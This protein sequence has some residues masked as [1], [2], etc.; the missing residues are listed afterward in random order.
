MARA[1]ITATWDDVPHLS[2]TAKAELLASY[3]SHQR[4]ARSRGIPSLGSGAIYPYAPEDIAEDAFPIP[5]H[6]RRAYALD[7]G[8]RTT[9][10]LWGAW[11][12]EDGCLHIY[13]EH[14]LGHAEPVVHAAAIRARG[15][16]IP[17]VVDPASV[18][19]SQIDGRRLIDIYRGLG[20]ALS[21]AD[22][23]VESGILRVQQGLSQGRIRIARTLR[24][25]F[26][27]YGEYRRDEKGRIVKERDHEMDCLRYL[28]VSG[29]AVAK[30]APAPTMDRRR[31]GPMDAVAGY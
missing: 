22:N 2:E 13:S 30:T 27:E 14:Y 6:W 5:P 23:S 18:G 1:L 10:A 25:F 29:E 7:V 15:E 20:L 4:D 17:G 8:W 9:A 31:K 19:A 21:E 24:R 26:G 16:W 3:P 28:T 11:A 12:P